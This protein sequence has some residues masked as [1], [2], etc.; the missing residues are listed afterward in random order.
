[1]M[2]Q[3]PAAADKLLASRTELLAPSGLQACYHLQLIS[4][5]IALHPITEKWKRAVQRCK[6]VL[7][8]HVK[9]VSDNGRTTAMNVHEKRPE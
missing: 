4:E 6:G 1:M 2:M 8:V 3:A 9:F 5:T 7:R